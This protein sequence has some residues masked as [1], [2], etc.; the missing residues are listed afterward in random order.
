MFFPIFGAFFFFCCYDFSCF[1]LNKFHLCS[2]FYVS[3]KTCPPTF[4]VSRQN[5][6]LGSGTEPHNAVALVEIWIIMFLV[7][8][9]DFFLNLFRFLSFLF[10]WISSWNVLDSFLSSEFWSQFWWHCA[11]QC[12]QDDAL[13]GQDDDA[14]GQDNDALGH[15][16]WIQNSEHWATQCGRL[17]W[18]E[19][20]HDFCISSWFLEFLLSSFGTESHNVDALVEI[21]MV[22]VRMMI[23]KM[24]KTMNV[25]TNWVFQLLIVKPFNILFHIGEIR[26]SKV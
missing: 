5:S 7:G 25:S 18:D 9:L 4:A 22:L 15:H 11:K 1:F 16:F 21:I 3:N 14:L 10:I 2:K 20:G 17:G 13:L 19:V 23:N 26:S 8:F 24:N 6:D 12:S